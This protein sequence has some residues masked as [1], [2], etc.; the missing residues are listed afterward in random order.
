VSLLTLKEIRSSI[1]RKV[2]P[3][4]LSGVS[5]F[6]VVLS[7]SLITLIFVLSPGFQSCDEKVSIVEKEKDFFPLFIISH[8][9]YKGYTLFHLIQ[10]LKYVAILQAL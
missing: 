5:F 7:H 3:D 10:E 6:R 8:Y 4:A 9:H 1:Q 2:V